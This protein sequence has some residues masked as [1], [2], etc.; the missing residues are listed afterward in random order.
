MEVVCPSCKFKGNIKDEHISDS[1]GEITCPHCKAEFFVRKNETEKSKSEMTGNVG[2]EP[3][4]E[5]FKPKVSKFKQVRNI[6]MPIIVCSSLL[7]T[8]VVFLVF[9]FFIG[10]AFYYSDS[11][12]NVKISKSDNAAVKPHKTTTP[13]AKKERFSPKK[14]FSTGK[15]VEANKL[16][17]DVLPRS[18]IQT[19]KFLEEN[20]NLIVYGTG[21]VKDV[22]E[23]DL[24]WDVMMK[25]NS[26]ENKYGVEITLGHPL[27]NVIM[28]LSMNDSD[29]MK[30]NRGDK[31]KFSGELLNFK[32]YGHGTA[33]VLL[34]DGKV[35]KY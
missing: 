27:R 10:V 4:G 20:I 28:G 2:S 26:G 11:E 7:V 21:T 16:I 12:P 33:M 31:V 18:E 22:K 29:V 23:I 9:G 14:L 13:P 17:E 3:P 35:V 8:A 5:R 15:K 6:K 19:E 24:F 25:N 32:T 34:Y 30:I 1:G